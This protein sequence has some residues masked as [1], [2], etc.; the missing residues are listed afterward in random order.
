M[1]MRAYFNLHNQQILRT[2]QRPCCC[3]RGL[4]YPHDLFE[5][6]GQK[7]W[8]NCCIMD[9]EEHEMAGLEARANEWNECNNR[10]A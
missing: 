3:C 1:T 9:A 8:C 2:Q 4:F 7:D 10:R 6:K 5:Y